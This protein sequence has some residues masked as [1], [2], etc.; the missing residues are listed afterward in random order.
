MLKAVSVTSGGGGNTVTGPGSSTDNAV[1]RWDGTTGTL[2]QNSTTILDDSGNLSTL[3]ITT[4]SANTEGFVTANSSTSYTVNQATGADFLITLTGNTTITV[5]SKPSSG[6]SFVVSIALNTGA[7]GFSVTWAGVDKWAAGS[8]PIIST[9]ASIEYY[10]TFDCNS[11]QVVGYI[12]AKNTDPGTV[13]PLTVLAAAS[14]GSVVIPAK[15]LLLN[16]AYN[17][18]TA[19]AVTGGL[20]IGTTSGGTDVVAAQSIGANANGTMVQSGTLLKM[21]FGNS[22]QTLFYDAVSSFNSATVDLYFVYVILA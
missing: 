10:L 7:G 17:N 14:A 18:N 9:T 15:A 12:A 21:F 4:T 22:S 1:T 20:K 2:V 11:T 8:A 13:F 6:K 3:S 19:N 5:P 16:I